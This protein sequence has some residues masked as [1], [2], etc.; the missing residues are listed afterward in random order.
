MNQALAAHRRAPSSLWA[1]LAVFALWC[2][3]SPG[4]RRSG[5]PWWAW[6]SV[7]ASQ[8]KLNIV[9][10]LAV[11]LAGAEIGGLVGYAIG[12]RWAASF[13]NGRAGGRIGGG[14]SPPTGSGSL[15]SGAGSPS[16]HYGPL[17]LAGSVYCQVQSTTAPPVKLIS[18]AVMVRAQSDAAKAAML[19]T[20]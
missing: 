20:S 10:V 4:Y 2:W 9:V 7:L 13:W 6:A 11:A 15:R 5:R 1:Y 12:A 16:R 8:G 19:A 18:L 14:R 3:R 17:R